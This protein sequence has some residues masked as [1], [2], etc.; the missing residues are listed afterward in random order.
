M[1]EAALADININIAVEKRCIVDIHLR[2]RG[3]HTGLIFRFKPKLVSILGMDTCLFR[4]YFGSFCLESDVAK[5]RQKY[6][7]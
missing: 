5:D 7:K 4:G 1:L 6:R 2:E 3:D